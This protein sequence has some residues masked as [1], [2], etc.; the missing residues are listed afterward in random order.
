MFLCN[1][2]FQHQLRSLSYSDDEQTEWTRMSRSLVE[3]AELPEYCGNISAATVSAESPES[4]DNVVPFHDIECKG[5]GENDLIFSYAVDSDEVDENSSKSAVQKNQ[6]P[7]LSESA[8]EAGLSAEEAGLDSALGRSVSNPSLHLDNRCL[9]PAL[10]ITEPSAHLNHASGPSG[11]ADFGYSSEGHS[12]EE[13]EHAKKPGAGRKLRAVDNRLDQVSVQCDPCP[14]TVGTSGIGTNLAQ[15]NGSSH[16]TDASFGA[17]AVNSLIESGPQSSFHREPVG[18]ETDDDFTGLNELPLD[19]GPSTS[20]LDLLAKLATVSETNCQGLTR[21]HGR[22]L[23]SLA[24]LQSD[25]LFLVEKRVSSVEII[26]DSVTNSS[27][28]SVSSQ[29]SRESAAEENMLDDIANGRCLLTASND[30]HKFSAPSSCDAS[31]EGTLSD[32]EFSDLGSADLTCSLKKSRSL[33]KRT[34]RPV[35]GVGSSNLYAAASMK[36]PTKRHLE[37]SAAPSHIT[38]STSHSA[39]DVVSQQDC[40]G[41]K[42][43]RICKSLSNLFFGQSP[44]KFSCSRGC[45]SNL[46][47]SRKVSQHRLVAKLNFAKDISDHEASC[48]AG[49]AFKSG[50][51]QQCCVS[52]QSTGILV[53]N[54]LVRF[55]NVRFAQNIRA[56]YQ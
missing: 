29:M 24:P 10:T 16:M 36:S 5:I 49:D 13:H 48:L 2:C 31:S 9:M 25:K 15:R 55:C 17:S 45:R 6:G 42:R 37:I 7:V 1:F 38:R 32:S 53:Q 46:V 14:D 34:R 8:D 33:A 28:P 51:N 41:V 30:G 20:E 12:N 50:T 27:R 40:P 18:E 26:I 23:D 21:A 47:S 43:S 3:D 11:V 54:D 44:K 56:I 4:F 35:R 52:H 39:I 19:D 22:S